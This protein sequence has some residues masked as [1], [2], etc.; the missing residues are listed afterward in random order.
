LYVISGVFFNF[1]IYGCNVDSLFPLF[2]ISSCNEL[3]T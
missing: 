3:T 2:A 1:G